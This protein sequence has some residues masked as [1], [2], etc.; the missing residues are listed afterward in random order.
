LADAPNPNDAFRRQILRYFYDRNAAATSMRGKKGAAVKISDVK[1][2]LK[3][4]LGLTQQQ[5]VSNLTY[6]IDRGWVE[7]EEVTKE[8]RPR[9]GSTS[10]PSTT[11]YYKITAKGIDRI[12]GGSD[13][14]PRER[15]G[16]INV[17][18]TGANVITLGDGNIVNAAF[19][20]LRMELDELK[21]QIVESDLPDDQKLEAA[22]DIET[23]KDQL[24]KA[25]PDPLVTSTLWSRV[26]KAALLAGLAEF[27]ANVGHLIAPIV[28]G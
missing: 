16:E 22:V 27:A 15:Y 2:E 24:A 20:D 8:V 7:V 28:G 6:L 17:N 14:E 13:F 23:I 9:G 18:A 25:D 11:A 19:N 26:E 4:S 21:R 5:V 1:K 12:E 10:V 3:A